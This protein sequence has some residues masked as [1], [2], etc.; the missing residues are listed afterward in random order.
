MIRLSLLTQMGLLGRSSNC[1]GWQLLYRKN[2][3][4][5]RFSS[6]TNQSRCRCGRG[7][8]CQRSCKILRVW[9][10]GLT[11]PKS[12]ATSTL[13]IS[14]KSL[15]AAVTVFGFTITGGLSISQEGTTCSYS[16]ARLISD[17]LLSSNSNKSSLRTFLRVSLIRVASVSCLL[18]VAVLA[19]PICV[20]LL[21][22]TRLRK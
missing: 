20:P 4:D 18:S 7:Y 21:L 15:S 8:L 16:G 10:S 9:M 6:M 17:T 1:M 2:R 14:N 22:M 11:S 3:A 12:S 5:R 13:L 19:I